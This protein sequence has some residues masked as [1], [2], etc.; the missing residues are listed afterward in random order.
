MV[1]VGQGYIRDSVSVDT[2]PRSQPRRR[3]QREVSR[4]FVIS[5]A[6]AA[7]AGGAA[8]SC[9]PTG[10]PVVDPLETAAFA[11]GFT[12]LASRAYRGTWLA[13]GVVCVILAKGWL[14]LPAGLT[15]VAAFSSVF[16]ERSRR[17][18]GAMVGA[19]G[20]QVVLR[21]PPAFFHGFPSL[22]AFGTVIL[23]GLSA[24]RR[25]SRRVRR[26]AAWGLGTLIVLAVLVSLP[27]LIALIVQRHNALAAEHSARSALLTIGNGDTASV[28]ADL[29][30][31]A[32]DAGMAASSMNWWFAAGA[33]MVPVVAQQDRFLVGTLEAA[34]QAASVGAKQAPFIDYH[35]LDYHQG[36]IDLGSVRAMRTPMAAL[37]RQLVATNRELASVL[38]P[39]LFQPLQSRGR[40][41]HTEVGRAVR[42]AKVALE[43]ARVI[44]AVLG[45]DGVRHYFVAFMTP[46]ES[47]GLDGILAAYGELTVSAGQVTLTTSGD[48][49]ALNET[50][51]P[52]SQRQLTGPK[53]FLA[54][55]GSFHPAEYPQ[56]WS[57]APDLPTLDEIVTQLYPEAGGVHIDGVLALDP[58]GLAALLKI[59]GPI[60]VPGISFPLTSDNAAQFL[61]R[62]QYTTFDSPG[63]GDQVRH[64]FLQDALRVAF[65]KLV[66]GSLPSPR[67]LSA[68]LDPAVQ[69]G[70]IGLWTN[71]TAPQPLLRSVGL[72]Q[73][74]PA[75]GRGNLLAVTTQNQG[76]NKLDAYIHSSIV[77]NV[78]YDAANGVTASQVTVTLHNDAPP[79]GLPDYVIA[80]D[81]D[82]GLPLGTDRLWLTLYSPLSF[83]R[84]SVNRAPVGMSSGSELG[85]HAYSM[86]VDVPSKGTVEVVVDLAGRLKA[87]DDLP[88]SVRTQ[89][90]A[91]PQAVRIVVRPAGNSML[92]SGKSRTA[93]EV[94]NNT[95][96]ERRFRFYVS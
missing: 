58:F 66:K 51:T 45:G 55:Y 69:Q 26:G 36:R 50:G 2:S 39:W 57:Y 4:L 27:M 16:S 54:R 24:W 35:R 10:T 95:K 22:V 7:A 52:P 71:Q 18:V 62:T 15:M 1:T 80:S 79:S 25:S 75:A 65:Q 13:F 87:G 88:M 29:N 91:N 8:A 67:I 81:K 20:I 78:A 32:A 82:P 11:A 73:A 17:R 31:A 96:E 14:L 84:A 5:L 90:S 44:P 33:R 12:L 83:H 19:L 23:L 34:A 42:G 47:R 74:F 3:S 46:A 6:V 70:R 86:F 89:P 63:P 68:D 41:F 92:A 94:P 61:L 28:T 30:R 85:V 37:D 38:S 64:D 76:N 56:D 40:T 93:W 43:A 9:H 72:A 60:A 59:T 48:V 21:W 53:S 49:S 77:D